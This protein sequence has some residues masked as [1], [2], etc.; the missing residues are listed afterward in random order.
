MQEPTLSTVLTRAGAYVMVFQRQLSGIVAEERYV[1]DVKGPSAFTYRTNAPV[2]RDLISDLL[3]VRP[4][5]ADRWIQFRD[6]FE[7]DGEPVRDRSER[8]MKLFVEPTL[9]TATQVQRIIDESARYNTNGR[10]LP[11]RGRFWIEPDTGRV[12]MTELIT[13]DAAIRVVIDVSYQS[14]PLVGLLVPVEM[15]ERYDL[16]S[17]GSRVAGRATYGRFRQFQVQVD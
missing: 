6:V 12:L 5:T 3:L 11:S 1:Q 10:D 14:E 8:L 16:H 7:V 9:S 4:A 13:E 2:S 15:H 17:D